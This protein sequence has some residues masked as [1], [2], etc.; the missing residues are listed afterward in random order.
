MRDLNEVLTSASPKTLK[1][2]PDEINERIERRIE[3]N[4]GHF[5][6]L[7]HTEIK[8]RLQELDSEWDIEKMLFLNLS[9]SAFSATIFSIIADK[10]WA[11]LAAAAN[12][13]L[14]QQMVKG[15]SPP[16]SVLRRMGIRTIDE[17]RLEKNALVALLDTDDQI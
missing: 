1:K 9:G 16:Y 15:W 10:K 8:K 17:I 14:L 5:K 3:A 13:F 2:S 12:G 4:V 7:D 11:Y 6:Q